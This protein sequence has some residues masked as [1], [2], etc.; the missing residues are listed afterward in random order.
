MGTQYE[1]RDRL[2][3]E[4]PEFSCWTS[5]FFRLPHA[6][7]LHNHE[8]HHLFACAKPTGVC[9][10]QGF[11]ALTT[12]AFLYQ[13]HDSSWVLMSTDCGLEVAVVS[14]CVCGLDGLCAELSFWGASL[15]AKHG[16]GSGGFLAGQA[17][18]WCKSCIREHFTSDQH[19]FGHLVI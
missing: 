14:V 16:H 2:P 12:P 9:L 10:V 1:G 11:V 8:V 4:P 15:A 19:R 5:P 17:R 3:S 6:L 13:R 7:C 18:L